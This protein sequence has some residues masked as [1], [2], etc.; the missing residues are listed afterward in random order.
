MSIKLQKYSYVITELQINQNINTN[1]Q[2][3]Q[4][5]QISSGK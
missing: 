4:S 2:I 5:M 3:K 1:Q